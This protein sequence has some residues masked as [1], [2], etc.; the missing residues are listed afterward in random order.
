[1]SRRKR[2]VDLLQLN[3]ALLAETPAEL[4]CEQRAE[5]ALALA[6]LFIQA[7]AGATTDHQ[8]GVENEPETN[9]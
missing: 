1:M 3:L 9:S 7:W 8:T 5:L 4:P 6:E 2:N